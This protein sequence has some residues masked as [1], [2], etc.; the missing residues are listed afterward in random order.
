VFWMRRSSGLRLG[1]FPGV[2]SS[3]LSSGFKVE[4]TK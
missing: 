4:L 2:G 3:I 1:S